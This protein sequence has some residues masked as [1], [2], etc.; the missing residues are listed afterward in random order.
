MWPVFPDMRFSKWPLCS[1]TVGSLCV[2]SWRQSAQGVWGWGGM[3]L[4]RLSWTCA[5]CSCREGVYGWSRIFFFPARN[6]V[7]WSY[8]SFF[9]SLQLLFSTEYWLHI[10]MALKSDAM[11]KNAAMPS[12]LLQ[13]TVAMTDVLQPRDHQLWTAESYCVK[14]QGH[15]NLFTFF[16]F[17]YL[18]NLCIPDVLQKQT[19]C[20]EHWQVAANM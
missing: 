14:P 17:A 9:P 5:W 3:L 4:F 2:F 19:A 18:T 7:S 20:S 8:A 16:Y 6:M 1:F 11:P 15:I 10:K 13:M 12:L